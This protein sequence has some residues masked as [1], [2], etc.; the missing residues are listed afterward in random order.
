L[1]CF[2]VPS[3]FISSRT[4]GEEVYCNYQKE[5]KTAYTTRVVCDT[6]DLL[7][8]YQTLWPTARDASNITTLRVVGNMAYIEAKG[9]EQPEPTVHEMPVVTTGP[10]ISLFLNCRY[11]LDFLK[12]TKAKV[13]TIELSKPE[14][15]VLLRPQNEAT[16]YAVMPMSPNR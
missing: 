11:M 9:E 15:S 4:I 7:C 3:H 10:D 8:G 6:A 5:L 13:I 16:V 1:S 2:F 14:C 12:A